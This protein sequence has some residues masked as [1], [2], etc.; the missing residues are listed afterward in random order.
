MTEQV[1]DKKTYELKWYVIRTFTG[2][3]QKVKLSIESEVKRLNLQE[4]VQDIIIPQETVFEVRGGKRR[5]RTKNFLPGYIVVKTVMDKKIKDLI[6]SIP[7]VVSFVGTKTEPAPLQQHEIERIIGR[8]EERKSIATIETTFQ[9]G[10]PVRVIDGPFTNFNG[11]VKEVNNEKQKL[12]VEVGILG[13]KTPVE[14]DFAQ[15]EMENH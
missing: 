13:R 9:I 10:D 3:E 12:K 7:S 2:H 4:K 11:T 1:K 14:L 6:N 8:V 15:V 5:T